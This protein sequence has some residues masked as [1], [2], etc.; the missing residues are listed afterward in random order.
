MSVIAPPL[1]HQPFSEADLYST[2]P[3]SSSS[4]SGSP[5][6]PLVT[7]PPTVERTLVPFPV[8]QQRH[9][10]PFPSTQS[11]SALGPPGVSSLKPPVVLGTIPLPP[12]PKPPHMALPGASGDGADLYS[13]IILPPTPDPSPPETKMLFPDAMIQLAPPSDDLDVIPRLEVEGIME[14]LADSATEVPRRLPLISVDQ[15][16]SAPTSPEAKP[17]KRLTVHAGA[18]L[19]ERSSSMKSRGP[20]GRPMRRSQ[21]AVHSVRS[22]ESHSADSSNRLR[23]AVLSPKALGRQSS[24]Y[25]TRSSSPGLHRALTSPMPDSPYMSPRSSGTGSGTPEMGNTDGLEAKVVLLGSQNAG[26]TSLIL[27]Y[28]TRTFSASPA[29]AT[30]GSSLHAR[31]LI[32][33]GVRVKLQIW[34]T[35]G[36]ERFRS[37]APIY[38]RG[39]H[40]CVL[41]YDVTDRS[42]FEDVRSWL[43]ELGRTVPKETVI[44][45]VGSKI[46]MET[47]RKISFVTSTVCGESTLTLSLDEAI[48]A[49]RSW[50]KPAPP[51]SE[52]TLS[53]PNTRNLLRSSSLASRTDSQAGTASILSS[54]VPTRSQ[55]HT[56]LASLNATTATIPPPRH[57]SDATESGSNTKASSVTQGAKKSAL[58]ITSVKSDPELT[59]SPRSRKISFP[60]LQSPTLPTSVT[61]T[62]PIKPSPAPSSPPS[63]HG[64]SGGRFSISGVLGYSRGPSMGGAAVNL[65]RLAEDY[66]ASPQ[67]ALQSTQPASGRAHS[68]GAETP[69]PRTRTESSPML[70]NRRKSEDWSTRPWRMGEGPGAAEALGEF[71]AGVRKKQSGEILDGQARNAT[72]P[73][74]VGPAN[75]GRARGGSLGRD[76]RLYGT[77]GVDG[78]ANDAG[79]G[80]EVEGMRVGEV[81]AATGEGVCG[82]DRLDPIWLIFAD[83]RGRGAVQEYLGALGREERED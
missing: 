8:F 66:P 7:T 18:L 65:A 69:S 43:E 52:S 12:A 78:P 57:S 75:K 16:A 62:E 21:T 14:N 25:T 27:R 83:I 24:N 19:G 36:Q 23:S 47:E 40:V 33:D 71:G 44:Y 28:T 60:A 56:A 32:H 31:K 34:D 80:F 42:S 77:S 46:D 53:P 4:S 3:A 72:V 64:V 13:P 1:N 74:I 10:S 35:A 41:V 38:Y 26:K 76:S 63:R 6:S 81:S 11:F 54:V 20:T 30:I 48:R 67:R 55:S 15:L 51:Q 45:V 37:M 9:S 58:Q 50:I 70:D 68:F 59:T 49:I 2:S 82:G 29:A 79:W 61:F 17:R 39:A 22:A 73:T 5:S